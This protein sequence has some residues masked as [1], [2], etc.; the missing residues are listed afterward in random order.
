[1]T[2]SETLI[3]VTEKHPRAIRWMH[4]INFPVLMLM[5]WSGL[6]IYWA[7]DAY[8]KIPEFINRFFDIPGRLAEGMGW[9][10][11]L[12]W[13]FA[14]NGFC[15]VVYLAVSGE[16]RTIFP[17]RKNLSEATLVI[18]HE[19]HLRKTEPKIVGKFNAAQKIAY[20]S[21]IFLGAGMLLTGVAIYKPVQLH[22][23][24]STLGG[25]EAAR[26][27]HFILTCL[28]VGFFIIHV[29]EVIRAGWNNFRAMVTGYEIN[30]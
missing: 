3:E 25:Y 30:K 10:F 8:I 21:V 16:W 29:S 27:E 12:M 24:T 9:Q 11:F 19:L 13:I 26:L 22:W 6:L 23:L 28:L 7:N 1:M 18:L 17:T 4:W 20:T 15:F 2:P 5:M 14:I